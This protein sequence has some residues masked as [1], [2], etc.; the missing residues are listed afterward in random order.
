MVADLSNRCL[1]LTLIFQTPST[2]SKAFLMKSFN[3]GFTKR[4]FLRLKRIMVLI[5]CLNGGLQYQTIPKA[6]LSHRQLLT[7]SADSFNLIF[8]PVRWVIKI[9]LSRNTGK[10]WV[11]RMI[12]CYRNLPLPIFRLHWRLAIMRLTVFPVFWRA[13]FFWLDHFYIA[14]VIAITEDFNDWLL[15]ILRRT[16]P[17]FRH[18]AHLSE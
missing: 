3:F 11:Q 6:F 9:I 1:Q 14:V 7:T 10:L 2:N 5:I 8:I 13:N 16:V 15:G 4:P 18:F 17:D 12:I